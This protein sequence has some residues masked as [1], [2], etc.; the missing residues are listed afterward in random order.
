MCGKDREMGKETLFPLM[1]KSLLSIHLSIH[2]S[3]HPFFG[4]IYVLNTYCVPGSVLDY[5][6]IILKRIY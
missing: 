3:I 6:D 2:P 4:S 1:G 5:E